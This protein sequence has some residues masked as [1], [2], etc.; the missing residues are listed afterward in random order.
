MEIQSIDARIQENEAEA[1]RLWDDLKRWVRLFS[2]PVN[3]ENLVVLR[4]VITE[5]GNIA[6]VEIPVLKDVVIETP[7]QDL[8]A[9]PTWFD[10]AQQQ[11]VRLLRL[12]VAHTILELQ[13]KLVALELKRTTQRVNLFEKVKIPE[14]R[15]NIRVI[16]IFLGDLQTAAVVRGKI[17]KSRISED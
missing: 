2:E 9:T 8:F 17:A 14:C 10:D 1:A 4:E 3:L 11:L 7:P 12:Q 5:T 15:E 6:G 13:R 16:R